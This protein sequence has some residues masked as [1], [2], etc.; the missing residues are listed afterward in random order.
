[1]LATEKRDGHCE[2]LRPSY[3][4]AFRVIRN[5][6]VLK[7]LMVPGQSW[8]GNK[9]SESEKN[10]FFII[11]SYN[12]TKNFLEKTMML[13]GISKSTHNK[14]QTFVVLHC[15]RK[16]SNSIQDIAHLKFQQVNTM[17]E[18]IFNM[19][20]CRIWGRSKI[21]GWLWWIKHTPGSH[22]YILYYS[23]GRN[24]FYTYSD[25][26]LPRWE[27]MGDYETWSFFTIQDS[28][29]FERGRCSKV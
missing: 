29:S 19:S 25:G 21:F 26:L 22:H 16:I 3:K 13:V 23:R 11:F 8:K 5:D 1:M 6:T 20:N 12:P 7:G 10:S 2:V 18:P 17:E 14:A 4:G 24:A 27:R 9:E 28:T 15:H